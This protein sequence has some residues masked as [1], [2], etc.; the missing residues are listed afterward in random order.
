M[1]AGSPGGSVLAR[2]S[3]S[4]MMS[5]NDKIFINTTGLGI[6][7]HDFNIS[8]ANLRAGDMLILSG[9]LG[10]HGMAEGGRWQPGRQG[11]GG[12]C[13][14]TRHDVAPAVRRKP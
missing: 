13:D 6:I 1:D 5:V 11:R 8:S 7:E 14:D 4:A 9:S 12:L 2:M 3:W 10:D